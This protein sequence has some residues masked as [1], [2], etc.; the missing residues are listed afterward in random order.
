MTVAQNPTR[1]PEYP[2]PEWLRSYV[3]VTGTLT[4]APLDLPR[5]FE[6]VLEALQ[7]RGWRVAVRSIGTDFGTI[8][9]PRDQPLELYLLKPARPFTALEAGEALA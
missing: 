9:T 1:R 3:L 8:P 4:S 6:A 2:R 5:R 7:A